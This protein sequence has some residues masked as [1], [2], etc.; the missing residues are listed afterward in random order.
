[1]NQ[2]DIMKALEICSK[3][4]GRECADCPF[5]VVPYCR[6]KLILEARNLIL[7]MLEKQAE[8]ARQEPEPWTRKRV[9]SEAEKC[10]CGQ[11]EQDYGT[12]EDS[13]EMIGKLWTVYLDYA[14]KSTHTTWRQ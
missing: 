3:D 7:S 4:G 9:L 6:S 13:F 12:P 14:T 1:M 10:V 11:R 2:E 5:T 8:D